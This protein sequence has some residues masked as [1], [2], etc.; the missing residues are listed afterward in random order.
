MSDEADQKYGLHP[1]IPIWLPYNETAVTIVDDLM[2]VLGYPLTGPKS[3]KYRVALSSLL[4]ASERATRFRRSSTPQYLGIRLRAGAW[5]Q[6]PKIG[7]VIWSRVSKEFVAHFN[8]HLVE[9][10]GDSGLFRDERGRWRTD[11]KMTMYQLDRSDLPSGIDQAQF[12][13]IGRPLVKLNKP[14]TRQQKA[15]RIS[16]KGTKPHFTRPQM[17]A[18]DGEAL[19]ASER[20][21]GRL[22]NFWRDHPIELPNGSVAASATRV[23]HDGSFT[24]GGRLYGA[25]TMLNNKQGERLQCTIDGEPICELDIRASQPTLLSCLLGTRMKNVSDQGTWHDP[26]L[27][28]T[29]LT[30]YDEAAWDQ[31]LEEFYDSGEAKIEPTKRTRLIAKAAVMEMI[32]SGDPNK[33]NPT[34]DLVA[35]TEVSKKEW[36]LFKAHLKDVIP[37]LNK[38]EP[39]YDNNGQLDGYING[40]GFLSFHESEMTIQ[41]IERLHE[42]GIPAYPVHDCLMV[43]LSDAK[44]AAKVYRDTIREYCYNMSGL[45][46]LVPLKCEVAEGIPTDDLFK[47]D[48]LRGEYLS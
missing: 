27:Q 35:S 24:S 22:N 21:I 40:A 33:S 14:E 45:N 18:I 46:V 39:R 47:G 11:P 31:Y 34:D 32:G 5:S 42:Q 15:A 23:F 36:D 19:R 41:A 38:L 10:S 3:E 26:Y 6:Y 43:K 7:R 30:F 48:D 20:L 17:E 12:I 8:G 44:E 25:W 13:D 4:M 16:D 1:A 9:G 29:G 37:A 28:L 2:S